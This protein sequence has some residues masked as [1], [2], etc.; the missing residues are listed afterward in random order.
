MCERTVGSRLLWNCSQWERAV[1]DH[2][3]FSPVSSNTVITPVEPWGHWQIKKEKPWGWLAAYLGCEPQSPE[4]TPRAECPSQG[5]T[6]TDIF[7]CLTCTRG[8]P[9]CYSWLI[10]GVRCNVSLKLM[11]QNVPKHKYIFTQLVC[12]N[13]FC[14]SRHSTKMHQSATIHYYIN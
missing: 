2:V 10:K 4:P 14:I 11:H 8:H 9:G 5:H 1:P 7:C 6:W 12:V 13:T 3:A